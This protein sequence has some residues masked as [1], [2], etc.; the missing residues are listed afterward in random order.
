MTTPQLRHSRLP[1]L[2]AAFAL[3]SLLLPRTADAQSTPSSTPSADDTIVLSPFVVT[4]GEDTGYQATDSLAGT[5]LRTPL[6]NIAASISVV[7]PDFLQ[8]TGATNLADLLVYTTGTEVTG[9]GGNF[10]GFT[11]NAGGS[12][13]FSQRRQ[14]NPTTRL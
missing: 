6:K 7:T 12:D 2:L 3:Q 5:R 10:G 11:A 1:A 8:D 4:S 14:V 9:I 13:N